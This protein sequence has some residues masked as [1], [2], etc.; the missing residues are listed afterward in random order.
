MTDRILF[1]LREFDPGRLGG[2]GY[3]P[4]A[5]DLAPLVDGDEDVTVDTVAAVCRRWPTLTTWVLQPTNR[6]PLSRLTRQLAQL[7]I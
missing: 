5:A 6:W 7:R 4:L 1:V 3:E 2:H